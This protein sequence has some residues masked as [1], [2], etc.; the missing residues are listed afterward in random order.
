MFETARQFIR[1]FEMD[2]FWKQRENQNFVN[3]LKNNDNLNTNKYVSCG[4]KV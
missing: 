3:Q 1:L 4:W 2:I